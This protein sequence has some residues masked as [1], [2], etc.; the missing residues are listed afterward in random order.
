MAD[1]T[2]NLEP[3]HC[4]S[5]SEGDGFVWEFFASTEGG[6]RVKVRLHF[7]FWWVTY[8]AR[9]LWQTINRRQ[10]EVDGAKKALTTAV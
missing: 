4:E 3:Y 1:K 9:D 8:L 2:I 6:K 5:K 10:E 7:R